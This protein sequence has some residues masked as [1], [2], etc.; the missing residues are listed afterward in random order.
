MGEEDLE[1][2]YLKYLDRFQRMNPKK[3]RVFTDP[4]KAEEWVLLIEK[5]FAGLRCREEYKV[6]LAIMTLES[7]AEHW[8]RALQRKA[9]STHQQITW[10]YFFDAFYGKYFSRTARMR[11]SAEFDALK[12][13]MK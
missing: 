4:D 7:E 1:E 12:Q 11:K 10:R 6:S 9:N 13:G 2:D 8:W 3:F 5:Y